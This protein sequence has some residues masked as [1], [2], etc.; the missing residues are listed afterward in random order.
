MSGSRQAAGGI[1]LVVSL[2]FFVMIR[3]GFMEGIGASASKYQKD[4]LLDQPQLYRGSKL[5][6]AKAAPVPAV[7]EGVAPEK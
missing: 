3:F 4:M 2:L 1:L 6:V 5:E 7:A